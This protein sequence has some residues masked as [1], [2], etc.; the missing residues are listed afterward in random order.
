MGKIK[1]V[2][3]TFD[4]GNHKILTSIEI[5]GEEVKLSIKPDESMPA[6][7]RSPMVTIHE[8]FIASLLNQ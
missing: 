2:T 5:A 4:D 3:V 7:Y 8:V 1:K 6:N